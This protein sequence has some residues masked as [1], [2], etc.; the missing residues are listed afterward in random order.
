MDS[1]LT[2][3]L[4][5]FK[6]SLSNA[7]AIFLEN[8]VSTIPA[9]PTTCQVAILQPKQYDAHVRAYCRWIQWENSRLHQEAWQQEEL[10]LC[11][12]EEAWAIAQ[13]QRC[14]HL[15]KELRSRKNND[16]ISANPTLQATMPTATLQKPHMV[17]MTASQQVLLDKEERCEGSACGS[18]GKV[19]WVLNT[20]EF[21]KEEED[22]VNI[23]FFVCNACNDKH[24]KKF[25]TCTIISCAP[26]IIKTKTVSKEIISWMSNEL[27][28]LLDVLPALTKEIQKNLLNTVSNQI[29]QW[30]LAG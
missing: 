30:D 18:R 27:I 23:K 8:E 10:A 20:Q 29:M 6:L 25:D 5:G 19:A 21:D 28:T 14:T 15:K 24:R 9:C 1:R 4:P 2:Y 11:K 12:Q 26:Y 22:L 13:Q 7:C 17:K 16:I 3:I